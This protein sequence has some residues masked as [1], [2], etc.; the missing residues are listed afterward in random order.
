L[1]FASLRES[2]G[3]WILLQTASFT[4]S[5]GRFEGQTLRTQKIRQK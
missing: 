1:T 5:T 3:K 2:D 4:D